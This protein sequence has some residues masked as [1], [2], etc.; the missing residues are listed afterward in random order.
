MRLER[1]K[2][3]GVLPMIASLVSATDGPAVPAW[4]PVVR[5]SGSVHLDLCVDDGRL[6]PARERVC[7][8]LAARG[9]DGF[10]A[11]RDLGGSA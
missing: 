2:R 6:V 3:L 10:G 7:D 4:V 1:V 5:D 8:Q 9:A 11:R